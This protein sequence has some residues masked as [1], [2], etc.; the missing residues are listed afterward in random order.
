MGQPQCL[1]T[2]VLG[3]MHHGTSSHGCGQAALNCM[4]LCCCMIERRL[5]TTNL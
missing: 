2:T 4:E 3:A 5:I 1:L